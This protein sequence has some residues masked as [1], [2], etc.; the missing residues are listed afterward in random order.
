MQAVL[1]SSQTILDTIPEAYAHLDSEFRF[2]FVNQAAEQLFGTSRAELLR[3]TLWDVYPEAAG[4]SLEAGF[5]RAMAE[6]ITVTFDNF[7]IS[8]GRWYARWYAIAAMPDSSGGLVV[9]FADSKLEDALR[10]SE[11]KFSKA[12]QSNPAAMCLMDLD[13]NGC[14]LDVNNAFECISGYR[15]DEVIGRTTTEFG[16]YY[17]PRDLEESRRRILKEGRYRNLEI[18]FRKKNGEVMVGLVSAE[19]IEI[20]GT[21]CAIAVALDVTEQRRAEQALRES[22]ELYRRLFE[23]E[24]DALVMVDRQSGQLL[25]ANAAATR[26]YGYSREEFLSLNRI[27]L[28]AEP[29]KTI[30]ATVEGQSFIP[31]RWHKKKDGTVFPVE[32]SG[33]YF[34]LKG[35]SVF[36]SAIRDIT[37]RRLMEEALRKSEE[38]FS[39]AFQSNPAAITIADLTSRTYLDVNDTFLELTGYSRDETVGRSW[40][41]LSLWVD[42]AQRD[43]QSS[44]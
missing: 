27:D 36:F 11:E 19:S 4:T 17:D 43:E 6:R 31:L 3:K 1:Q 14:F 28:S 12:F 15:R 21:L 42:P 10:K 33:S 5:R 2:T 7:H 37:D 29:E 8:G 44:N 41:E 18:R 30:R 38:K 9:R 22:E 26:L 25:A 20:N 35:R 39:K 16:M 23:V 34:D 24:S 13:K 40:D 32:I